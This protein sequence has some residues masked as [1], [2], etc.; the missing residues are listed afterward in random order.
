M[1]GRF[2]PRGSFPILGSPDGLQL[3]P[4]TPSH[5]VAI[6]S[7]YAFRFEGGCNTAILGSKWYSWILRE[8]LD[9]FI[10]INN[11]YSYASLEEMAGIWARAKCLPKMGRELWL[12]TREYHLTD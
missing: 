2:T 12:M 5:M 8:S 6:L 9:S 4:P 3:Q 10:A 11:I 7:Q 1:S